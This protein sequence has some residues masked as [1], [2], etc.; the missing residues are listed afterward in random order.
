MTDSDQWLSAVAA[1]MRVRDSGLNPLQAYRHGLK[2]V[3]RQR[4]RGED[5]ERWLYDYCRAANIR[6]P[7]GWPGHEQERKTPRHYNRP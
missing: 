4:L 6:V 5:H 2:L 1:G 3:L 7:E